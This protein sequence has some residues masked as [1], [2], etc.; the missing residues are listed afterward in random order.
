[1]IL[2][3]SC[4]SERITGNGDL[5]R[6]FAD[7]VDHSLTDGEGL[8]GNRGSLAAFGMTT[9]LGVVGESAQVRRPY[10]SR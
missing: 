10:H 5:C 9:A 3:R 6:S 1:M 8:K 2:A 7:R 4:G